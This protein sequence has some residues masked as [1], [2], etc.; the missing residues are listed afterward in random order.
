MGTSSSNKNN[1]RHKSYLTKQSYIIWIDKN[2]N[3]EENQYYLN[4][5]KK[6]NFE[7]NT[8]ENIEY[9]LN[10]ILYIRSI[11]FKDIYLILR[12]SFYQ[13]FILK[14]KEHLKDI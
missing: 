1:F 3:N 4:E 11:Y 6:G 10:E 2:I 5:F 13:D 7:I 12:G 8:Y 9:G 14:F